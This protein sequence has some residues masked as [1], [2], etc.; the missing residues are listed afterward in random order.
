MAPDRQPAEAATVG[1]MS[2]NHEIAIGM[3]NS[4][5]QRLLAGN[6]SAQLHAETSMAVEMAHSL[7]VIDIL[8]HR[9]YV[10]RQDRILESQHQDLMAKL[11]GLRA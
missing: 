9:Q 6:T 1:C 10:E 8:E 7:G 11:E 4:R 2:R 3:I 5:F